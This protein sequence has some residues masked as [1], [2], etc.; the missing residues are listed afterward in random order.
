MQTYFLDACHKHHL[1]IKK[2]CE[3]M[4]THFGINWI[5][6]SKIKKDSSLIHLDNMPHVSSNYFEMK[7]FLCDPLMR[8]PTVLP[9]GIVLFEEFPS[10]EYV[11][12]Q[13]K[14]VE[15]FDIILGYTYIIPGPDEVTLLSIGAPKLYAHQL[16]HYINQLPLIKKFFAH[17]INE[18]KNL[19]HK[20]EDD[21]LHLTTL[22]DQKFHQ[23][24]F[25]IPNQVTQ[26][27]RLGFIEKISADKL[28]LQNLTEREKQCLLYLSQGMSIKQVAI[29]L[30]LSPRTVENYLLRLKEKFRCYRKSDL[31]QK[32]KELADYNLLS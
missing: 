25:V 10:P 6:Y 13:K 22:I 1:Q 31:M 4:E 16:S 15:Q 9:A 24:D 12:F 23:Q 32:A 7:A 30:Q 20:I 29:T 19:I 11:R 3:P 14:N 17:F 8:S 5:S 27:H 2:L 21:P 18:T 28:I 26:T